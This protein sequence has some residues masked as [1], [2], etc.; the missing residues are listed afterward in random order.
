MTRTKKVAILAIVIMVLT[1]LPVQLFAAT[2][3]SDRLSGSGRVETSLE[4]ASAGWSTASTVIVAPADQANL[5]DALAVAPLA[6]QENA[7]ILL[8]FKD[9]LNADVK[10]KISALGAA[11]VYVIG[12]ISDSVKNEIAGISGATVEVLKGSNRWDTAKAI[13]AKLNSPAGT[14]VV[15]YDAIPDALSA[16]SY[17]AKN[18]F[19][20]VLA[21]ADGSI[22]SKDLV[23]ATKYIVGGETKVKSIDGVERLAG[24]DRYA[25]NKAIAEKLSFSYERVYVA[26]GITC[27]DALAVAP[28]A[29]KYNAFVALADA[30]SVAAA[31]VVKAKMN[32]NSKV[33]AVGGTNAVSDAVKDSIKVA[34]ATKFAVDSIEVVSL[35]QVKVVFS[36]EVNENNAEN[37]SNYKIGTTTLGATDAAVMQS[38]KKTVLVTLATPL[39]QSTKHTFTVN[40]GI[41]NN[42]GDQII[43]KCEK[44]L[45]FNDVNTPTVLSAK[46]TGNKKVTVVF[47]EPVVMTNPLGAGVKIDGQSHTAA[48]S[49][50]ISVK[51][52]VANE[53]LSGDEAATRAAGGWWSNKLEISFNGT[54]S[55]GNHT[56][57][58]PAGTAGVSYVDAAGFR[59]AETTVNFSVENVTGNPVVKS[60]DAQ[61]NGIVY[62]TF[63]RDMDTTAAG[64]NSIRT[65]AN[66]SGNT[67]G[68]N[69][70][71]DPSLVEGR[72]D[73]VKMTFNAG[74]IKEGS[75]VLILDKDIKDAWGNKLADGTQDIRYSFTAAKDTAKPEVTSVNLTGNETT[76]AKITVKF[77]EDV[78]GAFASTAANYKLKDASGDEVSLGGATYLNKNGGTTSSDTWVITLAAG[79]SPL[80]DSSYTLEV[81]NL[82]DL[83]STPNRMDTVVKTFSVG[84]TVKP[85]LRAAYESSTDN[86]VIVEFSEAMGASVLELKNYYYVNGA[87]EIKDLPTGTTVSKENDKTVAI[88]FPN[89]VTVNPGGA[90][91]DIVGIRVANVADAAG[92]TIAGG[93]AEFTL[94]SAADAAKITISERTVVAKKV[95]DDIYV[96]FETSE[97]LSSITLSEFGYGAAANRKSPSSYTIAGKEVT[98]KFLNT[99]NAG[100]DVLAIK[101]SGT[102][103]ALVVAV[104]GVDA[105]GAPTATVNADGR[106]IAQ[107]A[108]A[109][110]VI[111]V[112]DDQVA[113]E[114]I[115]RTVSGATT[116]D[117]TFT[118]DIDN[119]VY[120]LY[121]DDF[122]FEMNGSLLTVQSVSQGATQN[123]L[124]YTFGVNI[125]DPV[126]VRAVADKIDIR[127]LKTD[128]AETQNAYVPTTGDKGNNVI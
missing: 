12:A 34:A 93:S 39:D 88:K 127:D 95:G 63:D 43:S 4:I 80:T 104:G 24:A 118:E 5:V 106:R 27:V 66:F 22:N 67:A 60:V 101:G 128:V 32:S 71:A 33:I 3:D 98:L 120:G 77:N 48:G 99:T 114:V 40:A 123:V 26:N 17:A 79:V 37:T 30:N 38:D 76:G 116:I 51:N 1:M 91:A 35:N 14:F 50:A 107:Y 31:S 16:A 72:S 45:T 89:G 15:G 36:Q 13:N 100:A 21:N 44:E 70:N 68:A 42:A 58:V 119:S 41:L 55:A 112:Y 74:V 78:N 20:I 6:G 82:I 87:G 18:K 75:N 56:L 62:V 108:T 97:P 11:K 81:K 7:P 25:T 10:A 54:L 126:N 28:L 117:I 61:D 109:T 121:K 53:G 96:T 57:T 8:T 29:A 85:L 111:A 113:P 23:G 69:P 73:K 125:T 122:S 49:G 46:A 103:A 84:D 110:H 86:K 90:G 47:S 2:A 19:A 115:S 65:A 59:V 94:T 92:N 83:A 64:T 105:G 102:S 52:D 9:K 124:R